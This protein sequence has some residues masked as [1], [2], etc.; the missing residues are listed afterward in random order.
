MRGRGPA[1]LPG[2]GWCLAPPRSP[3]VGGLPR[4]AV[5]APARGV[6][7]RRAAQGTHPLAAVHQDRMLVIPELPVAYKQYHLASSDIPAIDISIVRVTGGYDAVRANVFDGDLTD[8]A[9][10]DGMVS[11]SLAQQ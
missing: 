5:P 3:L 7:A 2:R 11:I 9:P 1:R 8:L 4:A 10:M 6:T